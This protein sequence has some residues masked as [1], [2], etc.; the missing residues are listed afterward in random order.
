MK[1]KICL[2]L[3][4]IG[5]LGFSQENPVSIHA[6]TANIRIGEQIRYKIVVKEKENVRF[7]ELKLDSLGGV[8]IVESIPIDT[9]KER[10]E[11]R[12]ILTSFDSGVYK[13]PKQEIHIDDIRFYTD[14]LLINVVNVAV[15]TTKQKLFPIKAIK[16]EPK[17]LDD[18]KH[19]WWILIPI[20]LLIAGILY[21]VLRKSDKKEPVRIYI[22]PFKEAL[23]RL[24]A[25][26]EKKLLQHNKVKAYYTELT[27]IIR[28]YIEK[29]T[30]IPAL[31]S[32]TNELIETIIDF[33]ESSKLGIERKTIDELKTVLTGADL[34]KFAKWKP[35]LEEIKSDRNTVEEIL[36]QTQE[37]M[38]KNDIAEKNEEEVEML[39]DEAV[40]GTRSD[41]AERKSVFKRF[42]LL[43]LIVIPLILLVVGY[44]SYTILSE[45]TAPIDASA[46]VYEEPWNLLAYGFPTISLES[47]EM[48][49]IESVQLPE[50]AYTVMGDYARYTYGAIGGSLYISV[51]ATK[52]FEELG[53]ISLDDGVEVALNELE[54]RHGIEF[55]NVKKE[56]NANSGY[57]GRTV[58]ASFKHSNPDGKKSEKNR[59][60]LLFYANN[61]GYRQVFVSHNLKNEA[62]MYRAE[63]VLKSVEIK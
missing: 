41:S 15:D 14:S 31:E 63:R 62:D 26:D 29:D 56:M 12:Y 55:S 40:V 19:L 47:P 22:P 38:H 24:K 48:L 11:K 1:E 25:L 3:F 10:L 2:I 54:S 8:E 53:T 35:E 16:R 52:F 39:F 50:N 45:E 32:T 7:P 34:V 37:A 23:N 58:T 30:K 9:L 13:I 6:D 60:S 5:L 61:E 21:L 43:F 46:K 59:M 36:K 28:T 20:V 18:Y 44:F 27:D 57:E 51:A 17:S 4:F 49:E 42:R 33:N